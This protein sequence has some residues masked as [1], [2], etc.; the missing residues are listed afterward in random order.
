MTE[1][2]YFSDLIL[3]P[4]EDFDNFVPGHNEELYLCLSSLAPTQAVC[5]WGLPGSGKSHLLK[6]TARLY[7]GLY[8]DASSFPHDTVD[9]PHASR[10]TRTAFSTPHDTNETPHTK[11]ICVD[12]VH[13][14]SED[15]QAVL[16]NLYNNWQTYKATAQVFS[17]VVSANAAPKSITVREDL[18]NRLGWDLVFELRALDDA[19]AQ[20][21]FA[22]RA[23]D[24]GLSLSK[25]V[26]PWLFAHYTRDIRALLALLDALD[27][28]SLEQKRTITLPL[29]KNFLDSKEFSA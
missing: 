14:F 17:L 1:Q 5:I 12:D 6:A 7:D 2:L 25:E 18:R 19:D 8:F 22:Q 3:T 10:D 28:Y 20:L 9:T 29:L 24:K 13:L 21:A 11:V 27:A 26:T 15:Q 4:P 23:F 16:F